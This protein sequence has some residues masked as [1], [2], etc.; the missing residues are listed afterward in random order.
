MKR[1]HPVRIRTI[2]AAVYLAG[3]GSLAAQQALPPPRA[4]PGPTAEDQF[5]N[6]CVNCH[7]NRTDIGLDVRLS[8]MMKQWYTGVPAPLAAMARASA[9]AGVTIKAKHPAADSSLQDIPGRCLRC[10]GRTSKLA[11]PFAQMIHLIHLTGDSEHSFLRLFQGECT[12][13]HKLDKATGKWSIPSGP[14][15]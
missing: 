12:H 15:P 3:A 7:V 8:T 9:P 2:A 1:P 10:H 14:E 11:P 5:P 13:C 4:I 6:A